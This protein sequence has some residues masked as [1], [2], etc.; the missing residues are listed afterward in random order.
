MGAFF[1]MKHFDYII[2]GQGLAGTLLTHRLLKLGK[3]VLVIDK[4]RE[5]TSSKVA[6][7][8]TI[9]WF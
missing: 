8:A 4:H 9:Q 5:F 2:V 7:G 3:S 1:L 6:P